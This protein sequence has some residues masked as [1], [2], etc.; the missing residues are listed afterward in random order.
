MLGD[1]ARSPAALNRVIAPGATSLTES[2]PTFPGGTSGCGWIEHRCGSLG[3][4]PN[5]TSHLDSKARPSSHKVTRR[6]GAS[7]S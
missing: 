5:D 3:E 7:E 4:V 2:L 1:P 6:S